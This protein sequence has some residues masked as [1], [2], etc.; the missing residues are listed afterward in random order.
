LIERGA[1][2]EVFEDFSEDALEAEA[3]DPAD[4]GSDGILPIPGP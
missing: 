3:S 4:I 1:G 2:I